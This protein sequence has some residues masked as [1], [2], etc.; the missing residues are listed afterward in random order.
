MMASTDTLIDALPYADEGYD[1]P[2]VREA[3]AVLIE[4]EV[5]RYHSTKNYLENIPGN[6]HEK[7][8]T[9]AMKTMFEKLDS[10]QPSEMLS[11]KR[12][13]LPAPPT[14]QK[15]DV[16]AWLSAVSN[17]KAQLEH[18]E[19]R[20]INLELLKDYGCNSWILYL[21][22]LQKM[23]EIQQK[24]LHTLRQQIQDTNWARKKEHTEAGSELQLL[25]SQW[26]NLV[27][28]NYELERACTEL[29]GEIDVMENEKKQ[30]LSQLPDTSSASFS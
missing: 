7:W 18:Q 9:P 29:E 11:M 2:G 22:R 21:Q 15:H 25:N 23:S 27:A 4:E 26:I 30:K 8:E 12:C 1:N 5:K 20:L 17:S 19:V 14:G 13:E 24:R 10:R 3:A 28:K 6:L 16:S